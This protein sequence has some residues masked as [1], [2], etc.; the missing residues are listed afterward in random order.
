M[1]ATPEPHEISSSHIQRRL[2]ALYSRLGTWG[3]VRFIT[4]V[5][6]LMS[7]LVAVSILTAIGELSD[8]SRRV[9]MVSLPI[10]VLVPLVVAPIVGFMIASLMGSLAEAYERVR[11]ISRFDPLTGVLN[12]RGFFEDAGLDQGEDSLLLVAMVDIDD[13]KA[14][15]DRYGHDF[16][17]RVLETLGARLGVIGG[18]RGLV[19]RIGGDEFALVLKGEDSS[20]DLEA[21]LEHACHPIG[22]F[23]NAVVT[24]SFG[25]AVFDEADSI[26]TALA[27]A[28][29][30]LY[31][32]KRSRK[33]TDSA[34]A[35]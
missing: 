33:P 19:G 35:G 13:F 16:G 29:S 27:R 1:G 17:D 20:I 3:L 24:A 31:R 30:A 26:D 12:R 28:D 25:V 8:N 14:V 32:A 2:F 22:A 10:S 11:I 4:T 15:N 6:V 7:A 34:L 9:F 23:A 18:D 21:M 5:S